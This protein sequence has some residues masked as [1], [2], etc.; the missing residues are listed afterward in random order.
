MIFTIGF[1]VVLVGAM[2]CAYHV[3]QPEFDRRVSR[4]QQ[5][6]DL[7]RAHIGALVGLSL[8]CIG[9]LMMVGSVLALAWRYLP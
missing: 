2:L 7:N 9:G 8:A 4:I 1:V 5:W 6:A 3:A